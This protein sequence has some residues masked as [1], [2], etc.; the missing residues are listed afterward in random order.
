MDVPSVK[1]TLRG[2]AMDYSL[3]TPRE[4]NPTAAEIVEDAK[5]YERYISDI[6]AA[7]VLTLAKNDKT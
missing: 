1:N 5:I 3:R 6:H 7:K 4:K 2:W